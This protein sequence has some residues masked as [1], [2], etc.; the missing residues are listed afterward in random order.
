MRNSAISSS[1]DFQKYSIGLSEFSTSRKSP[2]F[3][4]NSN[5]T[6][7][8]ALWDEE[9]HHYSDF[10]LYIISVSASNWAVSKLSVE[11]KSSTW[12]CIDR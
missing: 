11:W 5:I 4:A 3:V 8:K 9:N 7:V 10:F 2:N 12:S 1:K 6:P